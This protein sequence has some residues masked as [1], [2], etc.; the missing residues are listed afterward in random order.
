M[1]E[2]LIRGNKVR[3]NGER[4]TE[5]IKTPVADKIT[6]W[7]ANVSDKVGAHNYASNLR[8]SNS[9]Q[10]NESPARSDLSNFYFGYPMN[11]KTLRVSP[12]TE[13][14]KGNKPDQ[15]YFMEFAYDSNIWKDPA[16]NKA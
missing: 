16:Y 3:E 10:I 9:Y 1:G 11:G 12:Y 6:S 8:E 15:G 5:E 7:L 4:N 2:N 13:T 14:G